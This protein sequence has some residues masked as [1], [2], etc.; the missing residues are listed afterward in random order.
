M[1]WT[2]AAGAVD[3]LMNSGSQ[4]SHDKADQR[5]IQT[6]IVSAGITPMILAEMVDRRYEQHSED[7]AMG[8]LMSWWLH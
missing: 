3:M 5:A 2:Y 4:D 1:K 8:H 7:G 6:C